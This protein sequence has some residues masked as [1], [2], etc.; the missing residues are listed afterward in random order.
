[1]GDWDSI[2]R[3]FDDTRKV[4]ISFA[5]SQPPCQNNGIILYLR[6]NMTFWSALKGKTYHAI[7]F[8]LLY[9]RK[10]QFLSVIVPGYN[11]SVI[12][13]LFAF[14]KLHNF[15][16]KNDNRIILRIKQNNLGDVPWYT[17]SIPLELIA[18]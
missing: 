11:F 2:S 16:F 10:D 1:M 17:L 8:A 6:G 12:F 13:W 9:S 7:S 3:F 15:N 5:N 4:N 18:L 14:L